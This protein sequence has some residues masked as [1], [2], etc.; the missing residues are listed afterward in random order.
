MILNK[1][2]QFSAE[3]YL[4]LFL[5]IFSIEGLLKNS[6][7]LPHLL[8]APALASISDFSINYIKYKRKEFP[9]HGLITGLIIALVLSPVSLFASIIIPPVAIVLKHVIHYKGRNIFNP[10]ALGMFV[11]GIALGVHA[12]WWSIGLLAIPFGLVVAYK[13]RRIYNPLSF[14][15]LSIVYDFVVSGG[16]SLNTSMF[17]FAFVMLLEPVTSPFTKK[18]QIIFGAS[19]A[20]LSFAFAFFNATDI[21]VPTLLI[22]NL[23][24]RRLNK[25][26]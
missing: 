17:F 26:K 1:L 16:F 9:E 14:V 18:G 21:F 20:L 3:K 22:L 6:F 11:S 8:L 24:T 15:V 23:F 13:I 2:N 4:I 5:V 7:A 25:L 10:A 12:A 19:A